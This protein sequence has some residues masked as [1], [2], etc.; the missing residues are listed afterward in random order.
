MAGPKGEI[1]VQVEHKEQ[2]LE[3]SPEQ[4]TGFMLERMRDTAYIQNASALSRPRLRSA[5]LPE[6][7]SPHERASCRMALAGTV[8]TR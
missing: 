3:L 5:P 8:N 4:V 6:L 1:L 7:M 2:T